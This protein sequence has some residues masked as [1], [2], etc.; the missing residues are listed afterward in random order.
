M[1]SASL[2]LYSWWISLMRLASS[3]SSSSVLER[4]SRRLKTL[5]SMTTPSVPGGA[6]K[7]ASLTS[8]AFSPK[9]ARRSL[10]SG[11]SSVSD[12]GVIL[13]TRISPGFTSA[14]MRIMPSSPR[15]ASASSET[16]GISRVISS[17]PSFVSRA[18]SSNSSR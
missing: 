5:T 14:P 15:F 1:S 16:F 17:F 3:T 13:P 11:A 18:V 12:F 8:A 10:S 7:D 6:V 4:R 2:V 9:I